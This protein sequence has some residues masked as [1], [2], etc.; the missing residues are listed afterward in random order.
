MSSVGIPNYSSQV[1]GVS[2]IHYALELS[3]I[4]TDMNRRRGQSLYL[5]FWIEVSNLLLLCGWE[6]E[7]NN[8]VHTYSR[9]FGVTLH[10]KNWPRRA[11]AGRESI[12]FPTVLLEAI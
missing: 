8:A 1:C 4:M 11:E 3:S 9:L 12:K 6:P 10:Y 2:N 7:V 5:C